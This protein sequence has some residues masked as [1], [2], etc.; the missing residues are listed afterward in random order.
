LRSEECHPTQARIDKWYT[1]GNPFSSRS[2]ISAVRNYIEVLKP[3]PTLLLAFIG[4]A[5]GFVAGDGTLSLK[6]AQVFVAILLAAAG[7]NGLT[8]YLD[9]DIDARML[10]TKDRALPSK[11]IYPPEKALPLIIVLI[12]LGLALAWFLHPFAF[13]ADVGGTLAAATWRK[14]VTCVYPQGVIASCAPV[15]MGWFA[16]RLS[17]SWALLWLCLLIAAWLPLHVWSVIVSHRD[18]Y[19]NAGLTYFPISY[20][21]RKSVRVLLV[22]S[23]ALLAVAVALYFA[24]NFGWLYLV[25]ATIMGIIMVYAAGRLVASGADR[26]SWRLYRLSAFPYLGIIFLAMCLDIWLLG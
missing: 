8:N 5:T 3:L 21:V 12:I 22:F 18:D 4:V 14:K 6:L 19:L 24:G 16:I 13:L 11:R 9:R 1:G 10:R 23:I 7:A 20:K 15:L 25:T 17:V 26:D 2:E